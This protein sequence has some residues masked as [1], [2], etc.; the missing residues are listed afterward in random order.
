MRRTKLIVYVKEAI[1]Q[2]PAALFDAAF[3]HF[4]KKDDEYVRK[5]KQS[6][7]GFRERKNFMAQFSRAVTKEAKLAVIDEWV[8]VRDA[9]S[10]PYRKES[11]A[12]VKAVANNGIITAE[13]TEKVLQKRID[14]VA[15]GESLKKVTNILNLQKE[16]D[17][18]ERV[19]GDVP[20]D[21][22]A[23]GEPES[24]DTPE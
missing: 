18:S 23:D 15:A 19:E 22:G 3:G 4:K 24:G 9:A 2:D 1:M 8:Q 20:V 10:F 12:L 14:V 7:V 5:N 21:D 16:S 11:D 17:A 13:A 6:P